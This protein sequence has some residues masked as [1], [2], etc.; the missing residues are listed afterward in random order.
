MRN[1]DLLLL[2]LLG[3]GPAF[4]AL[5]FEA[6]VID[7]SNPA[8][9]HCKTLADLDGDG[10]LDAV[11]ASSAGGGLYWYEAPGWTQHAI[12]ATGS[13]TTDMQAG[14]VDGD[15]DLDLVIPDSAGLKWYENPRPGGDPRTDPWSEHLIGAAGAN[16]HDV[17]VGDIEPDGDLDVVS[18]RKNGGGTFLWRQGAAPPVKRWHA[19]RFASLK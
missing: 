4:A 6:V 11:A 12:R 9:P 3:C 18:R 7:P 17:E 5:P 10:L 15:G 1:L 8:D 13:W 16:N 2:A 19:I 14:D